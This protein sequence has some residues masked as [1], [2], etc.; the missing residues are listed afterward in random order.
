MVLTVV[1]APIPFQNGWRF[2]LQKESAETIVEEA[3]RVVNP[4]DPFSLI[5]LALEFPLLPG[6]E[7]RR[8]MDVAADQANLGR[9]LPND[10]F[11]VV[12]VLVKGNIFPP[13][14]TGSSSKGSSKVN[15]FSRRRSLVSMAFRTFPS[16]SRVNS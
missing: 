16:S 12:V 2:H 10:Q 13:I 7:G 5:Y 11:S 14:R 15:W 8:S 3:F 1:A 4:R 9:G 6:P